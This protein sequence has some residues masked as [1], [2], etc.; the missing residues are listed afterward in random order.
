V[1]KGNFQEF[2]RF[3]TETY[4]RASSTCTTSSQCRGVFARRVSSKRCGRPIAAARMLNAFAQSRRELT[5]RQ[6][7]MPDDLS[8]V[9]AADATCAKA[10]MRPTARMRRAS[11]VGQTPRGCTT[12][13]RAAARR[14]PAIVRED[15]RGGGCRIAG[16]PRR[17]GPRGLMRH[18]ARRGR[19]PP[20]VQ[21]PARQCAR[22]SRP[23]STPC[24][25]FIAFGVTFRRRGTGGP[26][27]TS[28]SACSSSTGDYSAIPLTAQDGVRKLRR[29]D[30]PR[31]AEDR[32]LRSLAGATNDKRRDRVAPGFGA[33]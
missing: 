28:S 32:I 26:S 22:S 8:Y 14:A 12:R 21:L 29:T 15:T 25:S 20:S 6:L 17:S 30:Q 33:R 24:G 13:P 2:P 16:T 19:S 3:E 7:A 18:S 31:V 27:P 23:P 11:H 10:K 4:E 1:H 9:I 5:P